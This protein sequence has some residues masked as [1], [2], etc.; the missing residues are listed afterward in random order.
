MLRIYQYLKIDTR[1]I[2][3]A[4]GMGNAKKKDQQKVNRIIGFT[5]IHPFSKR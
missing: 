2:S 3:S 5:S 4:L 1:L